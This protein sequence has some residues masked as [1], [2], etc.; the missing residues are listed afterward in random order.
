M[1]FAKEEEL[2][3]EDIVEGFKTLSEMAPS[4][5]W[6]KIGNFFKT[7]FEDGLSE[8]FKLAKSEKVY[9]SEKMSETMGEIRE[10]RKDFSS[11]SL[12]QIAKNTTEKPDI[13]QNTVHFVTK[14]DGTTEIMGFTETQLDDFVDAYYNE[15]M[16]F[17]DGKMYTLPYAK[18]TEVLFYNK[19]EFEKNKWNGYWTSRI[20]S[21]KT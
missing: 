7:I 11:R 16:A 1:N 17:G 14:K 19:T 18:S 2:T 10:E 15:G 8:A 12:A 6:K 5:T 20:S 3:K 21:R 13:K 9:R 4:S